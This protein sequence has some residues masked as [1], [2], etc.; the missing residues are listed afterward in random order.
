MP[1]THSGL[2]PIEYYYPGGFGL[3]AT[4]NCLF[5]WTPTI[6]TFPDRI[7][8]YQTVGENKCIQMSIHA[9]YTQCLPSITDATYVPQPN[10]SYIS[11]SCCGPGTGEIK[12]AVLD[13]E[14]PP[15]LYLDIDTGHMEGIIDLIEISAFRRLGAPRQF[16]FDETNY[17][18]YAISGLSLFC[19][20]RAFDSG[21]TADFDDFVI[22]IPVHTNWSARRDK[23]VLNIEN[24]FYFDGKTVDNKTYLER[25]KSLGYYP[26]PNCSI[27]GRSYKCHQSTD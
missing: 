16:K 10:T 2:Y 21:N 12:Y 20:V 1:M 7:Y 27:S 11:S 19:L 4:N 8:E 18:K 14:F 22:E 6:I 13:G 15:S 24:Q 23:F 26:G 3:T 9:N 5:T 25:I 17:A